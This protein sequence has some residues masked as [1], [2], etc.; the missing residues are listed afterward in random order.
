[1]TT[2]ATPTLAPEREAP[3][4]PA[5][6]RDRNNSPSTAKLDAALAKAQSAFTA[7]PKNKTAKIKSKSGAE[8]SYKY[9]DLADVLGM[10]LPILSKNGIAF[11]QP[12]LKTQNAGLRVTT[13]LRHESGEWTQ[14]DGIG[15]PEQLT[16]Q[17]FGAILTYWRRYDGCAMLGVS[18][19]EDTDARLDHGGNAQSNT[20]TQGKSTVKNPCAKCKKTITSVVLNKGQQDEKTIPAEIVAAKS[21]EKLGKMLCWDC[22]TAEAESKSKEAP[23]RQKLEGK[24]TAMSQKKSG[25]K[26]W[27]EMTIEKV[28]V[29]DWHKSHFE[30]Y[31]GKPDTLGLVVDVKKKGKYTDYTVFAL[32]H[33][34]GVVVE[35]ESGNKVAVEEQASFGDGQ[36]VDDDIPF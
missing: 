11:S 12:L 28:K 17:E 8:F 7:V 35:D 14:S 5:I 18:P 16:P 26:T 9:A 24:V 30:H 10:A 36:I 32:L 33:V 20:Q 4:T 22:A 6:V 15:I 25:D 1:M 2:T 21:K 34:D 31:Q 27:W 3:T 29:A 23:T 19:D 13:R